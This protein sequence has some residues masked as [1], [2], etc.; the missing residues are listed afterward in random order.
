MVALKSSR[1]G[2]LLVAFALVL[3]FFGALQLL[4]TGTASATALACPAPAT[5]VNDKVDLDWDNLQLV[6]PQ[7][8]QA[9]TVADLWDL[10]V[11]L[12]WKTKGAVKAGDFFTYDATVAEAGTGQPILRPTAERTF[13][14][15]SA[16]GVV[17][18]CG[19]WGT[20][21][22]V[23]VV[24][25]ENADSAAEWAGSVTTS[26]MVHYTGPAKENFQV[27]VGNK[28]VANKLNMVVKPTGEARYAKEGWLG[29][30][31]SED[32]DENKA[33]M[34]RV[35]LP[36]GDQSVTGASIVDE[37]P[38]GEDW[39]FD[40]ATVTDYVKAHTFV[41]VDPTTPEGKRQSKDTSNGAF[42]A[43]STVACTSQKVTVNFP[44]IPAHQSAIVEIPSRVEGAKRAADVSGK[45]TNTVNFNVPGKNVAPVTKVAR[46]GAVADAFA[47]QTFSVI[48][49]VDGELPES[50]KNL[51]YTLSIT[52]KNDTDPSVN[53]TYQATVKAGKKYTYPGTLPLGTQVTVSEGDLPTADGITWNEAESR[54]FETAQGVSLKT[55]NREATFTLSEDNVFVLTLNNKLAPTPMPTPSESPTPT[56]SPT[57]S[58]SPTPTPTPS[59][60][61]TP[62]PTPTPSESPTPTPT[63]TPS[64]SPTPTPTPTPSESPTPTP[65]PTPSESPTP[66]PTPTPSTPPAP[67]LAKTGADTTS[68][69]FLAGLVTIAGVSLVIAQRRR[70]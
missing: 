43:G 7:G 22:I 49:K 65:T 21:G 11:K 16:N 48:K 41:V 9:K 2:A 18:G 4:T 15:R 56:P 6:N 24:F 66:T 28:L 55:N 27:Q 26:A 59:E 19:T 50:A 39:S 63:P 12:P 44:T 3:S 61:P 34:W 1:L 57:P 37:V 13:D 52:L 69:G 25:N 53:K 31:D 64:E 38:A 33:V 67:R 20:D 36:A 54:I 10:G 58:E 5:N 60:S 68:L 29:L 32:G 51:D 23:T 42:G 40:C 17:V 45:F 47:H 46:F 14:V 62:T 70:G 35:I 30:S 8:T